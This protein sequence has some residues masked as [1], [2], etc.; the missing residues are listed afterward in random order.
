ML[1]RVKEV[2]ESD[3]RMVGALARNIQRVI[4]VTQADID[5][6]AA[7]GKAWVVKPVVKVSDPLDNLRGGTQLVI[8]QNSILPGQNVMRVM[9]VG[10]QAV[11]V[12]PGTSP[13]SLP[14]ATDN[15]I[16]SLI[17]FGG[18]QQRNLPEGYTELEY[19]QSSGTQYID[20]GIGLNSA[21][22]YRIIVAS[23][24]DNNSS[25]IWGYKSNSSYTG[26]KCCIIGWT[27]SPTTYIGAYNKNGNIVGAFPVINDL[28]WTANT[29]FDIELDVTNSKF[30]VN[31]TNYYSTS[32]VSTV[33]TTDSWTDTHHPYLFGTQTVDS[34]VPSS[35]IM[36]KRYQVYDTNGVLIQ[37]FVP[38]K[39]ASNVVGMY[40]TVS[41]TFF[42]NAGTGDFVAGNAAVPTPDA[43]M[44]IICNNGVLKFGAYGDELMTGV[45]VNTGETIVDDG[46]TITITG[47]S[48][49]DYIEV[50]PNTQYLLKF[51]RPAGTIFTRIAEYDSTQT[52]ISPLLVKDQ[53]NP[54]GVVKKLF[55]TGANTKYLRFGFQQGST[56]MTLKT[57]GVYVNGIVET[58][59][60]RK[61]LASGYTELEY[62]ETTGT[63]YIDTD[64]KPDAD[65]DVETV[66][67]TPN[68]LSN[69]SLFGNQSA[70]VLLYL[71]SNTFSVYN[72]NSNKG[73]LTPTISA[74]AQYSVK[75][76]VVGTSATISGDLT[77]TFSGLTITG[78][79]NILLGAN[80]SSNVTDFGKFK[81][82]SMKITK[83]GVLVRNL[84]PAKRNSDSVLGMYDTVNNQFYT[85]AG[86]GTF[87]AGDVAYHSTATCEDLLSIG[88]NTDQ[89]EIISGAITRKVGV[90]VLDGTENIGKSSQ[91][92]GSFFVR[93]V[94][95][96]W[97]TSNGAEIICSH[98]SGVTA[99]SS[100]A[101]NKCI[102]LNN[103][104]NMWWANDNTPTLAQFQ[105]WLADQYAAGTPVIVIYP[106]A[107]ATT[108][109]VTAQPMQ[110]VEGDNIAEITQAS[111]NNLELQVEYIKA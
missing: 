21:Y 41:G 67:T 108:E 6:A 38:C 20:T 92:A 107:T 98:F 22:K 66:F 84:V 2:Q 77:G 100:Y 34:A 72:N 94:V 89:Q 31:G 69:G 71:S 81:Y 83:S 19:I 11:V 30:I 61:E 45:T 8:K 97:G 109:T 101:Q 16:L 57:V 47:G 32:G 27:G 7:Q 110:T 91:Y 26:G 54:T 4:A 90:K 39:N 68:T 24:A 64:I 58:I 104:F 18:T 49:T 1:Q 12:G 33:L 52:F 105:Q 14:D 44:D 53:T 13:L 46:T 111:L 73:A 102:I 10:G 96:D 5:A 56:D 36:V 85:N 106:L 65:Y 50:Q 76:S 86:S 62:I 17:A 15:D 3:L 80:Y 99:E 75:L 37:D 103:A 42:T 40:D 87:G 78:T 79:R 9:Y 93:N 55:T 63:Q 70:D 95:S 88:T 23:V 28:H 48:D 51:T 35:A 25:N 82:H 59:G 60:I 74:N 29:F 43:P